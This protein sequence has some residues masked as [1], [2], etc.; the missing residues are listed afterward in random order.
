VELY[1]DDIAAGESWL[2]LAPIRE[3]V[4][5]DVL[6]AYA[7]LA[8]AQSDPEAALGLIQ[9]AIRVDPY[10]EDLYRRAMRLQAALNNEEGVRRTLVA[11][12]ERLAQLD[13]E[14]SNE[15][16][17]VAAELLR[18]LEAGRCGHSPRPPSA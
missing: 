6:D 7:H 11:I 10:G 15:T 16:R 13:I 9:K 5:R 8:D 2:W 18:R 17:Q 1:T 14:V 4:R 3:A 12:T